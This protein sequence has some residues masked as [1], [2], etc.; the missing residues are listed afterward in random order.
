MR[1]YD[2]TWNLSIFQGGCALA[3]YLMWIWFCCQDSGKGRRTG[4]CEVLG[5]GDD[6]KKII[7]QWFLPL[8]LNNNDKKTL[9]GLY[10][11]IVQM[12]SETVSKYM[13]LF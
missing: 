11:I 1:Y 10:P 6:K 12:Y 9:M 13:I 3:E 7:L 2:N 8:L 4:S 5:K